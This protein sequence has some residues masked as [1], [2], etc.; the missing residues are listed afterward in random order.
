MSEAMTS[1][2]IEDVLTSIRRLV[3]EDL[4][5][6]PKAE[7]EVTPDAAAPAVIEPDKLILTAALRIVTAE[8]EVADAPGAADVRQAEPVPP[9]AAA[10]QN[11]RPRLDG[12]LSV[13]SAKVSPPAT[14]F[15]AETGDAF[16]A[17]RERGKLRAVPL[18]AVPPAPAPAPQPVT[19]PEPAPQFVHRSFEEVVPRVAAPV[20]APTAA[21]PVEDAPVARVS[22][23][24]PFGDDD[25][26][27]EAGL[28]AD[29]LN[30]TDLAFAPAVDLDEEALR[31]MIRDVLRE[32]LQ[33]QMGERITRNVR[34]LVR[35]EVARLLSAR[36]FE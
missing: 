35:A 16:D 36:S 1:A 11:A 24:D 31:D 7:V 4:R 15:E 28:A 3:S 18:A 27:G 20:A 32:E 10:E 17:R 19:P 9:P 14:G 21:A 30:P 5:P 25:L 34:K 29:G 12:V 26:S 8:P 13:I 22:V 23:A 6:R 2:D 33:G